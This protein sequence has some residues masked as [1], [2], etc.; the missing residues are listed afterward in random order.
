VIAAQIN[1]NFHCFLR[2]LLLAFCL[3]S[4]LTDSRAQGENKY[5]TKRWDTLVVNE[6]KVPEEIVGRL[7]K[8]KDF[9]YADSNSPLNKAARLLREELAK[10]KGEVKEDAVAEYVPLGS[11]PWFQAILWVVIVGGFAIFLALYLQ[12]S[13][14]SLFRKKNRK[15]SEDGE[16]QSMPEDIFAIN[17]QKE[18]D[19]AVQ[20]SNYRLAIRLHF[21]RLLKNMA[22]RGLITYTQDKT[23]FDYLSE[24]GSTNYYSRFFRA[25][26]NYEYSWYGLFPVSNEAYQTIR[27]DFDGLEQQLR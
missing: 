24:L 25:T 23:N 8:H 26:R 10:E 16:E 9:W 7:R 15:V 4:F 5:F 13:N 3:F 27:K 12:G 6:R 1:S 2:P 17:Y 20:Q 19:K 18:I 21:L 14:I 11:R 22:D